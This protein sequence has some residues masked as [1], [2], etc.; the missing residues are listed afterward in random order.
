VGRESHRGFESHT[1]RTTPSAPAVTPRRLKV[2]A[3][4]DRVDEK[5]LPERGAYLPFPWSHAL[6]TSASTAATRIMTRRAAQA[7]RPAAS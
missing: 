5:S 2:A 3:N 7:P 4:T 1:L 6:T